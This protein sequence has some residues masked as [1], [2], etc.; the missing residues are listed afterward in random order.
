MYQHRVVATPFLVNAAGGGLEAILAAANGKPHRKG[1]TAWAS[2]E[3]SSSPK[4]STG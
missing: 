3:T 4:T 2:T 1:G